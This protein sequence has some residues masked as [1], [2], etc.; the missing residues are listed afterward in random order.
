MDVVD[1]YQ[2]TKSS[3]TTKNSTYFLIAHEHK[4][5]ISKQPDMLVGGTLKE[6]Q[7]G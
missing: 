5:K 4:E 3:T 7:V 6:Y 2:D 1:E